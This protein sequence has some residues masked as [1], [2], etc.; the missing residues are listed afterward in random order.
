MENKHVSMVIGWNPKHWK[1]LQYEGDAYAINE[2]DYPRYKTFFAKKKDTPCTEE[3]LSNT[4]M[5]YF[6][7][8]PTWIGFSDFTGKKPS[9]IEIKNF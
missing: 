1:T 7:I 5:R 2:K 3:F 9:V 8:K 6:K 4:L